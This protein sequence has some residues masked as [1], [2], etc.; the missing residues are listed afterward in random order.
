MKV[1]NIRY[2]LFGNYD[3]QAHQLHKHNHDL[4]LLL[5]FQIHLSG[6]QFYLLEKYLNSFRNKILP[7]E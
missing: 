3:Q 5:C 1:I 6:T 4:I 7:N 2:L